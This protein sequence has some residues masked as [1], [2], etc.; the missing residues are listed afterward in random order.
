MCFFRFLVVLKINF[1]PNTLIRSI[2][3]FVKIR[4]SAKNEIGEITKFRITPFSPFREGQ[5]ENR[6]SMKI[7]SVAKKKYFVESQ[8]YTT[9]RSPLNNLSVNY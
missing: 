2:G 6:K 3:E 4:N 8:L 5:S 1:F 9:Y 7:R